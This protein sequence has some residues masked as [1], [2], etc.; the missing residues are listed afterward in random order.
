MVSSLQTHDIVRA[1]KMKT[2]QS[3]F[4]ARKFSSVSFKI[5]HTSCLALD[6]LSGVP[7]IL[8]TPFC[9]KLF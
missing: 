8:A 7:K 4:Y 1:E 5:T 3:R 9:L 2:N 6:W